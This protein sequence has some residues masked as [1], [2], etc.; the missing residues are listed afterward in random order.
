M[1]A[2]FG[3]FLLLR[4]FFSPFF[5]GFVDDFYISEHLFVGTQYILLA[6]GGIKFFYGDLFGLDRGVRLGIFFVFQIIVVKVCQQ[7]RTF[8]F[9][10]A[11]AVADSQAVDQYVAGHVTGVAEEVFGTMSAADDRGRA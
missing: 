9:S 1:S 8:V 6:A 3:I 7:C 11:V 2:F 4:V 10:G 5:S